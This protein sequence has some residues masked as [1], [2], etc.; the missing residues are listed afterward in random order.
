MT[1][2][3]L[4]FCCHHNWRLWL[5]TSKPFKLNLIYMRQRMCRSG[6]MYWM[7]FPSRNFDPRPWL[8][9]QL[10]KL[11]LH[12]EVQSTHS[13]SQKHVSYIPVVMLISW[14][15]FGL[16][17]VG[18]FCVDFCSILF[19]FFL[20]GSTWPYLTSSFYPRP[21][22]AFRYCH[23]LR[24]G[25]CPCPCVCVYQSLACP[26]DYSSAV[27]ARITKFGSEMQNT[28]VKMPIIFGG[29]QP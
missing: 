16:I 29:D 12:D 28:L 25:V 2:L 24:M 20:C 18:T 15:N 7:T 14:R 19:Y 1:R 11:C 3:S 6:K 8:C 13:I 22:L 23:R 27:Q 17:L 5:R 21:L 10:T 9:Y 4:H 26:H